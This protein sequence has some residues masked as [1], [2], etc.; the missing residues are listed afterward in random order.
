MYTSGGGMGG[1]RSGGQRREGSM[2]V[3]HTKRDVQKEGL[4]R[5]YLII[6]GKLMDY[7]T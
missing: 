5:E 7:V 4:V 2:E 6:Y 1:E 3:I